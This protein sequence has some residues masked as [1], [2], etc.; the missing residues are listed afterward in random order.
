MCQQ[1]RKGER[2]GP[3][4]VG[5]AVQLSEDRRAS[6]PMRCSSFASSPQVGQ[7]DRSPGLGHSD[8]QYSGLDGLELAEEERTT[9]PEMQR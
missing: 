2:N 6:S 4:N 3:G 8:L 9:M 1:D 7:W 5:F